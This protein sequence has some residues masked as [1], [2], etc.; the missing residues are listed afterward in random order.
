MQRNSFLFKRRR[1]LTDD[2]DL[3]VSV[4]ENYLKCMLNCCLAYLH[5]PLSSMSFYKPNFTF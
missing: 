2:A 5:G 4:L 1:N 3:N